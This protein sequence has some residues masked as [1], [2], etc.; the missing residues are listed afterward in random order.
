[1]PSFKALFTLCISLT[2]PSILMDSVQFHVAQYFKFHYKNVM[3]ADQMDGGDEHSRHSSTN[4]S[5]LHH[6]NQ[7][8][9]Y[10]VAI[11]FSNKGVNR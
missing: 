3:E 5:G 8:F 2:H 11:I 6:P 4:S 7:N 1:M 9:M 10:I